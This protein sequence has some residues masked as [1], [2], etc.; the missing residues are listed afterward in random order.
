MQHPGGGELITDVA[1]RDCTKEFE[2]FGHS[3][4]AKQTLKQYKIGELVEVS[5]FLKKFIEFCQR[6][7][8]S[9]LFLN[10]SFPPQEDKRANRNK[11]TTTTK[12]IIETDQDTEV[13]KKRR[14]IRFFFCA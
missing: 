10:I 1:G 3:S 11:K 8:S 7:N 5:A 6:K 9:F 4:D 13:I 14:K 2:D 12:N